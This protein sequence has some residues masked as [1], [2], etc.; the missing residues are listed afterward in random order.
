MSNSIIERFYTAFKEQNASEMAA[1]YHPDVIFNDPAFKNLNY[2]EVT[3]MWEM[4]IKRANGNLS[5]EH[6]SVMEDN[7]LGQCT[8]E[9]EYEFSK[10]GNAVHN[11]IHATMQF[12]DGKIITRHL[13]NDILHGITR[14]AVLRFA[15]E[16]QM[17]VEERAFTIDEAKDADEAFITSASTFVMPVVEIDGV[18][19]GEGMPGNVAARLREIYLDESRRTAV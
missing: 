16:A 18:Q 1:C 7:E 2:R 10:T 12:K 5:I 14:A 13:S 8:W 17:V 9:A 4:L 15:Q 19:L 11:I 3:A 6:H